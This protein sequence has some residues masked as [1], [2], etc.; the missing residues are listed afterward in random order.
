MNKSGRLIAVVGPSG[1]GKD[2]VIDGVLHALPDLRHVKR[3]IT[4]APGLGGEDHH[5]VSEETF[6]FEQEQGAYC[7]HWQA[8]GYS[9]GIPTDVLV[10]TEQGQEFIANLSRSVLIEAATKFPEL[11]VIQLTASTTVLASRLS[12]RGRESEEVIAARL[13]RSTFPMPQGLIVHR[14]SNEGPLE[15]TIDAMVKLLV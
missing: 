11:V 8:H 15:D 13:A 4:R 5:A 12:A 1:V 10:D 6:K 7:L 14:I 9:Y 3:T 2:S